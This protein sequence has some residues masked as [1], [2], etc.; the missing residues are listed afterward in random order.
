MIRMRKGYITALLIAAVAVTVT[1]GVASADR[2]FPAPEIQGSANLAEV[3]EN[4]IKENRK[5]SFESAAKTAE[6]SSTDAIVADGR[7]GVVQGYLVYTFRVIDIGKG[8]SYMMIVDAGNGSV[9][10]TSEPKIFKSARYENA[11]IAVS[12]S[13]ASTN[14][15]KEVTNGTVES[16]RLRVD[17]DG[18]AVYT[19]IVKN[20]EGKLYRVNVDASNGNVMDV[21]ELGSSKGWHDGYG[22]GQGYAH[23]DGWYWHDDYK[24]KKHK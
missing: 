15:V 1:V 6:S 3:V 4:F 12:M 23:K 18:N 8:E 20:S 2:Y 7:F 10:Y 17:R 5:I 19:F 14:A 22:Y 24:M 16:G 11:N 13:S 9:L 21:V